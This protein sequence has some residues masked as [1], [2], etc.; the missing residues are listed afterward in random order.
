MEICTKILTTWWMETIRGTLPLFKTMLNPLNDAKSLFQ[1]NRNPTLR[2]LRDTLEC[3]M[4][5]VLKTIMLACIIM[6]NV[7]IEDEFV[8][9]QFKES[10]DEDQHKILIMH[11]QCI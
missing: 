7:T 8:E 1:R 4:L 6:H 3:R 11:F 2:M 5:N 10:N 9:Y